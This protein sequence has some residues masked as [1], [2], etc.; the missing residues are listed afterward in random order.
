[1]RALVGLA[2]RPGARAPSYDVARECGILGQALVQLRQ[3][4]VK[5]GIL[6]SVRGHCGG[7]GLARPAADISLLEVVEAVDGAVRCEAG[8]MGAKA[9]AALDRRLEL[10]CQHATQAERQVLAGVTV[11]DLA[12]GRRRGEA[13]WG[14]GPGLR[15]PG[16]RRE[17][18]RPAGLL[19]RLLPAVG[20]NG[21]RWPGHL[22]GTGAVGHYLAGAQGRGKVDRAFRG[23]AG[24]GS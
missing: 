8:L 20:G 16:L 2:A 13:H 4:L 1:V 10:V 21:P 24:E 9:G 7:Y 22:G 5:V 12:R 17:A 15:L 11:A 14:A 3:P 23:A 19:R 18:G 6:H